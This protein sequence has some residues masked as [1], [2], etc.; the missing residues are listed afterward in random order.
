[1][2]EVPLVYEKNPH[3]LHYALPFPDLEHAVQHPEEPIRNTLKSFKFLRAEPHLVKISSL[4]RAFFGRDRAKLGKEKVKEI[5]E[6]RL[7]VN[8]VDGA[9]QMMEDS[10]IL[11]A[12]FVGDPR[13]QRP[14]TNKYL[15]AFIYTAKKGHNLASL[16]FPDG[17]PVQTFDQ[18][19]REVKYNLKDAM[20]TF[21]DGLN[22]A[23]FQSLLQNMETVCAKAVAKVK[24]KYTNKRQRT[25]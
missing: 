10:R 16:L 2:S 7:F 22:D 15:N 5:Y 23:Q 13:N 18:C 6:D 24:A 12:M 9:M 4:L 21:D 11:T 25:D 3:M 17:Y 1:M 20:K 8:V 19:Y 14:V